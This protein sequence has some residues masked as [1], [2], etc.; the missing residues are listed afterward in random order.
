VEL[1]ASSP[2]TL[3]ACTSTTL[4]PGLPPSKRRII[5][6]L[7]PSQ[8]ISLCLNVFSFLR[9]TVQFGVHI[10]LLIK[11]QTMMVI[12]YTSKSVSCMGVGMDFVI[13][14]LLNYVLSFK[15]S[16]NT[17]NTACNSICCRIQS[18]TNMAISILSP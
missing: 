1:Y 4:I 13:W 15:L 16:I 10:V 9:Y 17:V 18:C 3:I 7:N 8:F 11:P 5:F 12:H 2:C 6:L 14:V